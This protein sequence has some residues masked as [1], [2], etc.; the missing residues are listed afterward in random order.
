MPALRG[1]A[2][3]VGDRREGEG[4]RGDRGEGVGVGVGGSCLFATGEIG[5][6]EAVAKEG[7]AAG[8]ER[9]MALA[10]SRR[11]VGEEL[12]RV[13]VCRAGEEVEPRMGECGT[14]LLRWVDE[15]VVGRGIGE[16]EGEA[17]G[18]VPCAAESTDF[19]SVTASVVLRCSRAARLFPAAGGC[20]CGSEGAGDDA[21]SS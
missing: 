15:E 12:V 18:E 7:D 3:T 16:R 17:A 21:M 20:A 14:K 8:E 19:I 2:G 4:D 10:E 6:S 11:E 5:L 1:S 9:D 13:R